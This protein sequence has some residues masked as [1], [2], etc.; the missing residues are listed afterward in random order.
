[1]RVFAAILVVVAAA[2]VFAD[3]PVPVI[4]SI[5]PGQVPVDGGSV[6]TIT[7]SNFD[8]GDCQV[9]PHDGCGPIVSFS[10][11]HPHGCCFSGSAKVLSASDT[12]L[13]V[14]T[15]PHVNGLADVQVI[16]RSGG[17]ATARGGLRFGREGFRRVLVPIAFRGE[18][19]GAFGSRWVTELNGRVFYPGQVEVTRTPFSEPPHKVEGPFTFADLPPAHSGG[20]FVYVPE[21]YF[22]DLSLRVRDVSRAQENFGTEV[23]LVTSEE[24]TPAFYQMFLNVPMGPKYRQTL[25]IYN[26]EGKRRAQIGVRILDRSGTT[27]LA[28]SYYTMPDGPVEEFPAEP[29]YI[30][31]NLG[32]LLPGHEGAVDVAV[33]AS[34]GPRMWSMVSVTNNETQMVTL[35]TPTFTERGGISII[36]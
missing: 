30:E 19:P 7:G 11:P 33:A 22:L 23:P 32:D 18:V 31:V 9:H 24:T 2:G 26:F 20:V 17:R 12:E 36:Q 16:A 6:V 10:M 34:A 5:S 15:P 25:R 13:I 28:S 35:V 4:E 8:G 3:P 27:E 21:G 29:G 14:E 1:M